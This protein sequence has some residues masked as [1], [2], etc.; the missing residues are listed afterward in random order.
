MKRHIVAVVISQIRIHEDGVI[1]C[2]AVRQILA[3]IGANDV[4]LWRVRQVEV[5][6]RHIYDYRIDFNY[7]DGHFRIA[8]EECLRR[9]CSA[10]PKHQ[11]P[12]DIRL[13]RKCG[14]EH[15]RIFKRTRKRVCQRHCGLAGSVEVESA[16]ASFVD[17]SDVAIEESFAYELHR[18]LL[19]DYNLASGSL[20]AWRLADEQERECQR[21][22]NEGKQIETL[23]HRKVGD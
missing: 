23:A 16:D 6:L 14:M 17:H 3:R 9:G 2:A 20:V 1:G 15:I 21:C 11:Y 13:E 12:L 19:I 22:Q 7:V 5:A 4:Q 8:R 10:Q 18:Y